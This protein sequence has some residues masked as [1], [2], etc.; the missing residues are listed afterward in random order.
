MSG[1]C[2]LGSLAGQRALPGNLR[3]IP[4]PHHLGNQLVPRYPDSWSKR[5]LADL[6]CPRWL[7]MLLNCLCCLA[8][9]D[10]PNCSNRLSPLP[11]QPDN[12]APLEFPNSG[13]W[14]E[15]NCLVLE[16]TWLAVHHERWPSARN[17][18]VS[19]P[20]V[21]PPYD[22]HY[23]TQCRHPPVL[24][25]DLNTERL[26]LHRACSCWLGK[27][28]HPLHRQARRETCSAGQNRVSN[29]LPF[30]RGLCCSH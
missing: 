25:R 1:S 21:H 12:R 6:C 10:L 23:P 22:R 18:L 26:A 27:D 9:R 24:E 17:R 8:D 28:F 19:W 14:A 7:A 2:W 13:S 29:G 11:S 5:R 4:I 20:S 3:Q 30:R 15:R 16:N